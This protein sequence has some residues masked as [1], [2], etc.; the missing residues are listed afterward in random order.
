[1]SDK[2]QFVSLIP[3][4]KRPARA[5]YNRKLKEASELVVWLSA[6][7]MPPDARQ[8][9]DLPKADYNSLEGLR[10]LDR[11]QTCKKGGR[12]FRQV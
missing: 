7:A 5:S 12:C 3:P 2:L 10:P 6:V 4:V 8:V 1:M 9:F 11:S